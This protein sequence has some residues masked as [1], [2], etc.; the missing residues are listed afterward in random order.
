V[1]E[2]NAGEAP[3]TGAKRR[4]ASVVQPVEVVIQKRRYIADRLDNLNFAAKLYLI[5]GIKIKYVC[6]VIQY[7]HRPALVMST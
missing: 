3:G 5:S 6:P 4:A 1:L 2:K 7:R